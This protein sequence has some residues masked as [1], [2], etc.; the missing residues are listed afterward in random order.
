MLISITGTAYGMPSLCT[1]RPNSEFTYDSARNKLVNLKLGDRDGPRV[2]FAIPGDVVSSGDDGLGM[3][4]TTGGRQGALLRLAGYIDLDSRLAVGCAG[5]IISYIQRKRA[6]AFLPGDP[7]AQ[8][9]HCISSVEM[10]G[11]DGSMQV[12]TAHCV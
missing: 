2:T 9:M 5:S 12:F 4:E 1:P 11:L 7:A 6:A 3:D 10:F 8:S